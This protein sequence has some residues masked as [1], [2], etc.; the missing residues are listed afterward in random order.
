MKRN[1]EI[2][3]E[4]SKRSSLRKRCFKLTNTLLFGVDKELAKHLQEKSF[5]P[6]L[7]MLCW[8]RVL[9][10]RQ[11]TLDTVLKVWDYFFSD[12]DYA[13]VQQRRYEE[14]DFVGNLYQRDDYF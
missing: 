13:L 12:I 3:R 5:Q 7:G 8:L 1:L 4:E 11:F 9:Y 14:Y 10:T 6:E 2:E